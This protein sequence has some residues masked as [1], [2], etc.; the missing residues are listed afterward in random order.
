[1]GKRDC[2]PNQLLQQVATPRK[3]D[4]RRKPTVKVERVR[5][6]TANE[7]RDDKERQEAKKVTGRKKKKVNQKTRYA[8]EKKLDTAGGE[9]KRAG[10]TFFTLVQP[11]TAFAKTTSQTKDLWTPI[12]R[13]P[14]SLTPAARKKGGRNDRE[15]NFLL[16]KSR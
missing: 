8:D 7:R 11:K 16:E 9:N 3:G 6:E 2:R 10:T 15:K 14:R 13:G 12:V 4:P 1:L 5:T